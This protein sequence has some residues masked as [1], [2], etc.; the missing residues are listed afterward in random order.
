MI[1]MEVITMPLSLEMGQLYIAML[2]NVMESKSAMTTQMNLDVESIH[3][4]PF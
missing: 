1:F 4:K 3:L 2:T